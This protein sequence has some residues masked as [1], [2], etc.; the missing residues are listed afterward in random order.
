MHRPFV[1]ATG[2]TAMAT[3][4]VVDVVGGGGDEGGGGAV[5][6]SPGRWHRVL[7]IQP[8]VGGGGGGASR[9]SSAPS[10]GRV[11]GVVAGG[12]VNLVVRALAPTPLY[13]ALCDGGPPT[14]A[15]LGSPVQRAW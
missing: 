10:N 7:R 14:N 8:E 3:A 12:A 4:G 15:R 6:S 9:R 13:I 2:S 1:E 5:R 11:V